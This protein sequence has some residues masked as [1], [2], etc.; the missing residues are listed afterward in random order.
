MTTPKTTGDFVAQQMNADAAGLP[1][2]FPG[3]VLT[4][5]PFAN[6]PPETQQAITVLPGVQFSIKGLTIDTELSSD[7][8]MGLLETIQAIRSAYQWMLG[9]WLRYGIKRKYGETDEQLAEIARITGKDT[10]TLHDYYKTALLFQKAERS[11]NCNFE[12]HRVLARE[13]P[14]KNPT[15]KQQRLTWLLVAESEKLSGRKLLDRIKGLGD[16]KSS[17][18]VERAKKQIAPKMAVWMKP[19]V[20]RDVKKS[21]AAYLRQCADELEKE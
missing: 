11:E 6:L 20:N 7:E 1:S 10:K 3:E 5:N 13:F 12:I 8:W 21:L 14:E 17:T 2:M 16:G 15:Q 9:D 18:L 4:E 19:G